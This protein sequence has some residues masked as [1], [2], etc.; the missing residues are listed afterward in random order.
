MS[1]S[2]DVDDTLTFQEYQDMAAETAIYPEDRAVEYLLM[3]LLSEAGELAGKYKKYLRDG[4]WD[5]AKW[6]GEL[7]DVLWYWSELVRRSTDR[8]TDDI[9]V[10]N[11]NKLKSRRDRGV[12]GGS[13]D[14]R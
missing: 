3:G 13:G 2:Y 6:D 10:D 8:S 5:Q 11:Y 1:K 14:T 12:L 9:A 4:T 7:G